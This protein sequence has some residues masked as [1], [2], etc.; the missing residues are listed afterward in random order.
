MIKQSIVSNPTDFNKRIGNKFT[1]SIASSHLLIRLV[2]DIIL[3][4]IKNTIY[5]L[6][7]FCIIRDV[8][9]RENKHKFHVYVNFLS[10]SF[11][12][13]AKINNL[14]FEVYD[15]ISR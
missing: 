12:F 2:R 14:C 1:S 11:L 4:H 10:N 6:N 8:L 13:G 9:Y 15:Q 7:I 5:F 3:R